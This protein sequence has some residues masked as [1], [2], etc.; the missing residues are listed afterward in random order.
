MAKTIVPSS[1]TCEHEFQARLSKHHKKRMESIEDEE[2]NLGK[3]LEVYE[4]GIP[5]PRNCLTANTDYH[6]PNMLV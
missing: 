1:S 5:N 6:R 3:Y 4:R 2:G